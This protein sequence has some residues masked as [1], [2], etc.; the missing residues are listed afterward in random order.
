MLSREELIGKIDELESTLKEL[1]AELDMLEEFKESYAGVKEAFLFIFDYLG[2]QGVD[3]SN[4]YDFIRTRSQEE[5]KE[6]FGDRK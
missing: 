4:L 1:K 5:L 6:L 2:I 3:E